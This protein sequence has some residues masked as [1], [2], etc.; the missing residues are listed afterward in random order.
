M[1]LKEAMK[2]EIF[3]FL[4]RYNCI[5]RGYRLKRNMMK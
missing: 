3:E 4:S 2:G 5:K 1:K